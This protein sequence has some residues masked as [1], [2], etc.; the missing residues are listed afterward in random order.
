MARDQIDF[1]HDAPVERDHVM[2]ALAAFG[3]CSDGGLDNQHDEYWIW[4]E[5]EETLSTWFTLQTQWNVGMAGPTG[6]NYPGVETCMRLRGLKK[7]LRK[8]MFPLIQ[9]MERA[10]LEEW[11]HKRKI[12]R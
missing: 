7:K 11:A 3:L 5:N 10:C 2:D 8:Q 1:G 12:E 6:L 4:P 9:M